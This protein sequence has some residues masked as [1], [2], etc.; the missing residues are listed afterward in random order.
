MP[1]VRF[2]PRKLAASILVALGL[3]TAMLAAG[4][5]RSAHAEERHGQRAAASTQEIVI[6]TL[7]V[8][9]EGFLPTGAPPSPGGNA[10]LQIYPH[11]G[12]SQ[13]TGSEWKYLSVRRY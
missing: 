7:E 6:E 13:T 1:C 12:G 5:G 11:P 3:A 10:H 8:Q 4:A 2:A 9:H